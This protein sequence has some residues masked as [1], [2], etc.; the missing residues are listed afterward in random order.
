MLEGHV[1]EIF[2]YSIFTVAIG[3][4]RRKYLSYSHDKLSN[5]KLDP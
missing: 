2:M 4:Q 1:R 5:N 3:Y